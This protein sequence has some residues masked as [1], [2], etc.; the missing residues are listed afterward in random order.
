MKYIVNQ[1]IKMEK[2]PELGGPLFMVSYGMY[3]FV[4]VLILSMFLIKLR[5]ITTYY[6]GP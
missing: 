2:E 6:Y 3:F 1:R 4:D 5:I